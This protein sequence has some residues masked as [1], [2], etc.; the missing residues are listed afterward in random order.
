MFLTTAPRR[1][2]ATLQSAITGATDADC[3]V[4]RTSDL[5]KRERERE[6]RGARRMERSGQELGRSYPERHWQGL[7]AGQATLPGK[8]GGVGW[9]EWRENDMT[10]H[11]DRARQNKVGSNTLRA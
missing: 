9:R 6:R 5:E 7:G 3:D 10:E 2:E 8:G 4:W 1:R 11:A